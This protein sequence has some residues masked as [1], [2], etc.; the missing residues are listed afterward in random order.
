MTKQSL[1]SAGTPQEV[2]S[3]SLIV[4][5]FVLFN[6]AV[7]DGDNVFIADTSANALAGINA[8]KILAQGRFC[9]E[10]DRWGALN[11]YFDLNLL[12][13]DGDTTAQKLIVYYQLAVANF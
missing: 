11:A 9:A 3:A 13:W 5:S 6:P 12:W 1:T 8:D 4:T 2:S 10:A 7:A